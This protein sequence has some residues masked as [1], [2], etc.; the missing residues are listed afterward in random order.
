MAVETAVAA[1]EEEDCTLWEEAVA[2]LT[3]VK[4]DSVAATGVDPTTIVAVEKGLRAQL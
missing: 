2:A 4:A 3:A 1:E